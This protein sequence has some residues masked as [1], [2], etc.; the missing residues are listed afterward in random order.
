VWIA[1]IIGSIPRFNVAFTLTQIDLGV[2]LK[3]QVVRL[4]SKSLQVREVVEE[5]I[6]P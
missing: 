1:T 6:F 3:K 4:V 2:G 5:A